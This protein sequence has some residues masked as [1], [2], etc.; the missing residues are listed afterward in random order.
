MLWLWAS[1]GLAQQLTQAEYFFDTDPGYGNGNQISF[2]ATE[3]FEFDSFISVDGLSA[4]FHSFHFR[5]KDENN[6]WSQALTKGIYLPQDNGDATLIDQIEYFFDEDP[7][8]GEGLQYN[9]FNPSNDLLVSFT[10]EMPNLQ[11][12][13]HEF[14][15]RVKDSN[16]HWSQTQQQS[17]E[18]LNC[19]LEI[20]GMVTHEDQSLVNDAWIY[21]Y[22]YFGEG[23][24][25]VVDSIN[26]ADGSY[27]FNQVCPMSEYFLKVIPESTTDYPPCYYGNTMYWQQ[28]TMI[29]TNQS[30]ITNADI[31][32]YD[33]APMSP[34]N[35]SVNGYI[36]YADYR[37]EPVK[38]VDIVLEYDNPDEKAGFEA[39]AYDRTDQIGEWNILNLPIGNFRIKVEIPGLEMDTTYYVDISNDGTIVEN[40]NFTVDMQNGIFIDY[41]GIEEYSISNDIEV[42]PN[43]ASNHDI[44]IQSLNSSTIIEKIIIYNYSGQSIRQERNRTQ[45]AFIRKNELSNGLYL[46]K[47]KTNKGIGVKKLIIN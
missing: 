39:V 24:A 17:F 43:P 11:E 16:G 29:S 15:L 9:N 44:L 19:D 6:N 42:F 10:A 12:G 30:S 37:G 18:L 25:I 35:S 46:I 3:N 33:F 47:I 1:L 38:N 36:Y 4:G 20:S 32:V 41:F 13:S 27:S 40:L 23:A 28:A 5:I 26:V 21:L 7:G 22:Q 14:F 31:I 2:T 8:F 45:Q 34:G